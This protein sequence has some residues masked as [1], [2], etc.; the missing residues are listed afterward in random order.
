MPRK[1]PDN[2]K[3]LKGTFRPCRAEQPAP[4]GDEPIGLAP[5]WLDDDGR[6]LYSELVILDGGET[7]HRAKRE[8]LA[9]YCHLWS[10][11]K[12]DPTSV[13]AS[14]VAQFRNLAAD[15]GIQELGTHKAEA[16][17]DKSGFAQF[18]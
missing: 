17:D 4:V 14:Y 1:L 6:E 9:L 11:I 10:T 16:K 15:I 13:N 3:K 5:D 7:L 18:R 8:L 2:V 12:A